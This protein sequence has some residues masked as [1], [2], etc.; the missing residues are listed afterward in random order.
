MNTLPPSAQKGNVLPS[1]HLHYV[2]TY[3]YPES[4]G[5][6]IFYIGKG[7]GK[8]IDAHEHEALSAQVGL[9][10][11]VRD[12]R[13]SAGDVG[14]VQNGARTHPLLP[15]PPHGTGLKVA[16]VPASTL[17]DRC[18]WLVSIRLRAGR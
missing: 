2:Y 11:L 12:T 4:M 15:S 6:Y 10:D 7:K 17:P 5:G 3:A 16:V 14:I 9:Q 18:G 13:Q 8:R 1:S